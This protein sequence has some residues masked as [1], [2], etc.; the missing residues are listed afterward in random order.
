M[1][2]VKKPEIFIAIPTTGNI[3][4]ELASF[5][6]GLDR[7]TYNIIVSFTIGG[8][9]AHNRNLLVNS[10]LKTDYEWLLFIDSDVMPPLNVL[11]MVKNG[12]DICSGVVYQYKHGGIVNLILDKYKD[13]YKFTKKSI[14]DDITEIDATGTGCLLINRKVFNKMKKPYFQFLYDDS[15]LTKLSED[16]NFC[17]EAQVVG[18]KI[19]LDKRIIAHHYKIVDLKLIASKLT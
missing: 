6:L 2:K 13:V 9:I 1:G 16:L 19:W 11:D 5:L 10:F 14:E 18:F 15:G 17:K 12:K 3:R 8:G 7:R 4:T